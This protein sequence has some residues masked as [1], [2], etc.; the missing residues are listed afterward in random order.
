MNKSILLVKENDTLRAR[1]REG[2]I[3]RM[4]ERLRDLFQVTIE[5]YR[6]FLQF[7]LEPNEI[8]LQVFVQRNQILFS[9]R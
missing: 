8:S 5:P 9:S 1:R 6:I 3:R 4:L 7:A 2:Q